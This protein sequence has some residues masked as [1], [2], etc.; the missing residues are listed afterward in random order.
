[1]LEKNIH[2]NFNE[3]EPE[4]TTVDCRNCSGQMFLMHWN[5]YL[6]CRLNRDEFEKAMEWAHKNG[7]PQAGKIDEKNDYFSIRKQTLK[8]IEY[9]REK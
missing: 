9:E 4:P 1:M 3:P 6:E 8:E 5:N 2:Q 7:I